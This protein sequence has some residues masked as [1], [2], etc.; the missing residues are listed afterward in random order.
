MFEFVGRQTKQNSSIN[1]SLRAHVKGGLTRAHQIG[2]LLE[3]LMT[4]LFPDTATKTL[5]LR[6]HAAAWIV[7]AASPER[8][9][10]LPSVAG[11]SATLTQS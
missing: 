6:R 8:A 2:V 9:L 3:L 5:F 7:V 4:P 11:Q 10:L 1:R